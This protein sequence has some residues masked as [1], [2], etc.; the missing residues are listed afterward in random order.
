MNE[1]DK[2]KARHIL[3]KL[4]NHCDTKHLTHYDLIAFRD[5]MDIIEE[6]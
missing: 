6:N 5:I 3:N 4:F 1:Y 2:R